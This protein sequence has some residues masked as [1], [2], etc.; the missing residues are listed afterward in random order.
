MD[1]SSTPPQNQKPDIVKA[2]WLLSNFAQFEK[3]LI[4]E[5]KLP[6]HAKRRVALA[7]YQRLGFPYRD[8]II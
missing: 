8:A 4:G 5:A 1:S 2:D 7:N 3:G 6:L